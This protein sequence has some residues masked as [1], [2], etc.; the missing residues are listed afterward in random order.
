[1]NIEIDNKGFVY[2]WINVK[3]NKWYIGSHCGDIND[4]YTASGTAIKRAFKKY[5]LD[6][7]SREILYTGES[8]KEKEEEILLELNAANDPLSYNL[9]NTAIGGD[10]WVGRKDTE[11]YKEYIKKLSQPGEKNGMFGR[12]HSDEIKALISKINTGKKSWNAGIKGHMSK[13]HAMAFSRKGF[14]HSKE[15]KK[16]MSESRNG[17]KNANAKKVTIDNITYNSI[18]DASLATGLSY[19]KISKLHK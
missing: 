10:V 16:K 19:Y 2:K 5:G 8:Y 11:E 1:M 6:S 4:G 18:L 13:E 14:K 7:F 12:N 17:S 15:T 9:K 3:N